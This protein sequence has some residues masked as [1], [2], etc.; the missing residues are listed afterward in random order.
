MVNE[1]AYTVTPVKLHYI[2]ANIPNSTN[3]PKKENQIKNRY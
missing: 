2:S 1:N 3:I